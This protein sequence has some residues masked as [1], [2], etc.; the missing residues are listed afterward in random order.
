MKHNPL[1]GGFEGPPSF[2]KGRV[3]QAYL[4]NSF[5]LLLAWHLLLLAWHLLLQTSL[6][7]QCV[8]VNMFFA[9]SYWFLVSHF[10]KESKSHAFRFSR[11]SLPQR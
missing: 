2:S 8:F 5:L 10:Q 3:E 11:A 1:N 6:F 7:D 4:I 9:G